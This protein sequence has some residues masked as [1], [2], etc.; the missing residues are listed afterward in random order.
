LFFPE[1]Y[2][3]SLNCLFRWRSASSPTS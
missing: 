3:I 1:N 2:L